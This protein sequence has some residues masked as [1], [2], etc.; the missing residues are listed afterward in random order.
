MHSPAPATC[1]SDASR[2][3]DVYARQDYTFDAAST[4]GK[5][6]TVSGDGDVVDVTLQPPITPNPFHRGM[7][8]S[9]L[10]CH[11]LPGG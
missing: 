3:T 5:Y 10:G 8:G 2:T 4:T 7:S 11:R 6:V 1:R 9:I